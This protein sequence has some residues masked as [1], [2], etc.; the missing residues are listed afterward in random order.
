MKKLIILFCL[1]F[2]NT[3]EEYAEF[4]HRLTCG[5]VPQIV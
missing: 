4:E 2:S 3:Y 5:A 1:L